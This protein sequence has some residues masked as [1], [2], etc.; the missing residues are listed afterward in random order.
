MP[1]LALLPSRAVVAISGEEASTFLD[2]LITANVEDV[3]AGTPSYGALLTPQGKILFDFFILRDEERYLVDCSAQQKAD[4]IKRLTFYK[5]RAKVDIAD[6]SE[7]LGVAASWGGAELPGHAYA[8]PRSAGA[9]QRT[10]ASL[11]DL[12]ALDDACEEAYEAHRISL[13]LADSDQDIG[14]GE[15]FPHEA[16]FD[17]VNGVHFTKGCY[18]GQEV[19]SRMRHKAKVRKRIVI[20]H[21][22]KGTLASGS[23]IT[24]DGKVSGT[25]LSTLNNNGLALIRLDRLEDAYANAGE[26]RAGQAQL[27][28]SKPEWATFDM[29]EAPN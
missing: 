10:V 4:L 23:E 22:E 25:V 18:V 6:C 21:G 9:G 28:F 7:E 16:N 20:A 15:L 13:G 27:S 2:G 24:T 8:D 14:S 1:T 17:Q 26:I 11:A 12:G 19:V 5:L 3:D 29:P